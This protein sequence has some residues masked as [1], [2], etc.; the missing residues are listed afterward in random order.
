VSNIPS[1]VRESTNTSILFS[2]DIATS[3]YHHSFILSPPFTLLSN[4]VHRTLPLPPLLPLLPPL[5]TP[6]VSSNAFLPHSPSLLPRPPPSGAEKAALPDSVKLIIGAGGIY[7]A[8]LYYGSL[9]EDVFRYVAADG[10]QFK[11]AWFLQVLEAMANVLVGFI[12]LQ[13]RIW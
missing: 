4:T 7:A 5:P 11:Q 6:P 13:V 1:T 8:F 10:T 3:P 12:G 2:N 9:Q